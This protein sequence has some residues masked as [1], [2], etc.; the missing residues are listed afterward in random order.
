MKLFIT[1]VA[2]LAVAMTAVAV[3]ETT[4][5]PAPSNDPVAVEPLDR[6]VPAAIKNAPAEIQPK[7]SSDTA[8]LPLE[9]ANS[10]TEAQAKQLVQDAGY[11]GISTLT[12]DQRGVWRGTA[13]KAGAQAKIAVD[14]KGNVVEVN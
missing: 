3:A 13:M 2:G 10:F 14:F 5:V 1:A 11:S 12:K 7:S 4:N 8:N 9:G 6:E